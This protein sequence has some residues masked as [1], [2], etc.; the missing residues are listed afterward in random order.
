MQEIGRRIAEV[1]PE[2]RFELSL[3][4]QEFAEYRKKINRVLENY[5]GYFNT[6]ELVYTSDPIRTAQKIF[7]AAVNFQF[8]DWAQSE[9]FDLV[10]N[11]SGIS[12]LTTGDE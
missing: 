11:P 6:L 12:A 1:C 5:Q 10:A 7:Y 3:S 9:I 2:C 4:G 8:G